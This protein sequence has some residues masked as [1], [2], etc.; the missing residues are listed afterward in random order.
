MEEI[1]AEEY[2]LKI[3]LWTKKKNTLEEV[4]R[5]AGQLGDPDREM[6]IIHV[7][8][9]NGK[10]S[11]C[12]YLTS[13]LREAGYRTG[14]FV[15]PHLVN[16][17]ERFLID[18]VMVDEASF[19]AAFS[20]VL[21]LTENM[22]KSGYCHPTFFEFLFLMG[23][24]IFQEKKVDYLIL[25]TGMGGR[26]DTT[27][28]VEKPEVC[29]ITSISLDHM[30]YLGDTLSLIAGEKAGIIKPGV[31]VV[32]DNSVPE[33]SE[34]IEKRAGEMGAAC[35]PVNVSDNRLEVCY[36]AP[37]QRMNSAL[38]L[39]ALELILPGPLSTEQQIAGVKAMRWP[40]RMEQV[41]PGV[42][43]DGAHNP[44]GIRAFIE[45]AKAVLEPSG[46]RCSLVFGVVSDKNYGQMIEEL[47]RELPVDSVYVTHMDNG[48]ALDA[49]PLIRLFREHGIGRV[50]GL[51]T[52]KEAVKMALEEKAEN[53]R[54]FCVGSLY[55]IGEIKAVLEGVR[56]D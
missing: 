55:L 22:M 51:K 15:S 28:I 5:F 36:P 49:E 24:C 37:Y 2:L 14:A 17:R 3:P 44:G 6:K 16:I 47:C 13:F 48:R 38:A 29:I 35:Y 45:A 4:R 52:A 46:S 8:G 23:L 12:A 43:L 1:K 42:F 20:R 26:L 56:N 32:Y 7:A 53:E 27:N 19:E 31:P 39:K 10:G 11:V 50:T 34:V 40:G 18:G 25:E 21:K 54:L 33:A 30:E 9:T 41:L